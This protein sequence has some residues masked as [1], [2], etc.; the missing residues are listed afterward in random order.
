MAGMEIGPWLDANGDHLRDLGLYAAGIA[1]YTLV[2]TLLYVPMGHRLM[3]GRKVKEGEDRVVT[4]GRRT[5]YVLFFPL[6]SF[7]FFLL[8]AGA[9][10][11]LQDL[12]GGGGKLP[13]EDALNI[14]MGIVIAIRLVA[15]FN[16]DAAQ[17]LGKIMPL[18]LL[19]VVLVTNT[20]D[21][22]VGDAL[23]GLSGFLD[24]IDLVGV[25]FFIMVFVEF[26]LRGLWA[27]FNPP[28]KPPKVVRPK[29]AVPPAAPRAK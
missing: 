22:G 2:V 14:S 13:T 6:V 3:F 5:M 11:F 4:S 20:L 29:G 24:R 28:A 27:I 15:Y 12:G 16:E 8:I 17:E 26:L 21:S 18:G 9:L 23:T 19:G 1:V 25:Y 10:F 7:A